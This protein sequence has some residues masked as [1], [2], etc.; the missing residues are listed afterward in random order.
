MAGAEKP[1]NFDGGRTS[2]RTA[3]RALDLLVA[4]AERSGSATLTELARSTGLSLATASRLLGTLASRDLV[5]RDDSGGYRSGY[6]LMQLAASV[7]RGET[8]YELAGQHLTA[9]ADESRETA[10]LGIAFDDSRA[11]YLRQA[12][13]DQRVQTASWTGR[14]IPREG[15]AMGDAL[16]GRVGPN[17]Y[18]TSS[19]RVEP[20]ITAVAAPV[21][22]YD[23]V[24][25]GALSIIAPTYRTGRGDVGRHGR[26]LVEHARAL[27]TALG[28]PA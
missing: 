13:G 22:N 11:L 21:R 12:S 7:L 3:D 8:L 15:T 5:R 10:N 6:G 26:L 16:A 1:G 2:T 20:D 24:I 14:T 9:L 25:I 17:G 27:S 23:G 19:G 28:A 18:A 4:V